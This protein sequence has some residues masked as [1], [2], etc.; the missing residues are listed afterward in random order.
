[1]E[2][3]EAGIRLQRVRMRLS[4]RPEGRPLDGQNICKSAVGNS[5]DAFEY[6]ERRETWLCVTGYNTLLISCTPTTENYSSWTLT[7]IKHPI[8][9]S[10]AQS[11]VV[12]TI[13]V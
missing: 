11:G 13:A 2:D 3:G 8:P 7:S 4:G 5:L 12:K 10:I 6:Y 1:M 9:G